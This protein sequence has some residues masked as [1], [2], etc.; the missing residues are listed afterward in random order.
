MLE[1]QQ[2]QSEISEGASN[3]LPVIASLAVVLIGVA[4]LGI[5]VAVGGGS[6]PSQGPALPFSG[7]TTGGAEISLGDYEGDV[8][9]LDFWATWC[10][11]CR[12][13]LPKVMALQERYKADGF[14]VIGISGDDEREKLRDFELSAEINY[15]TIFEGSDDIYRAYEVRA[16]PTMILINREGEI[17]YRSHGRGLEKRI[18]NAL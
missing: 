16:I 6:G 13:S 7:K 12:E 3:W 11:P 9:L 5:R 4:A 18:Q 1:N 10:P 15:P 8:V 14:Q 2:D 17:V